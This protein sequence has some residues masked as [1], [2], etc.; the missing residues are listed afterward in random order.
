MKQAGIRNA[1]GWV[2][3]I[4]G[5]RVST[6]ASD[7]GS[8][9]Y[10][11]LLVCSASNV[12]TIVFKSYIFLIYLHTGFNPGLRRPEVDYDTSSCILSDASRGWGKTAWSEL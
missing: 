7:T 2:A 12:R 6:S 8:T 11:M 4:I 9:G 5:E 10:G 3:F 1:G